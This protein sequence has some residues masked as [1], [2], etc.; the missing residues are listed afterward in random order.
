MLMWDR[1]VKES[2]FGT[3]RSLAAAHSTSFSVSTTSNEALNG[4]VAMAWE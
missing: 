4:S 2:G 3:S 1:P